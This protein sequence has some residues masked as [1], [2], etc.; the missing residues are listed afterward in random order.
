[1]IRVLT[2]PVY[3]GA[4]V[5]GELRTEDAHEPLVTREQFQRVQQMLHLNRATQTH[6]NPSGQYPFLLK[7]V[8]RCKCGHMMTSYFSTGRDGRLHF[9]Y[10]CTHRTHHGRGGC[11]APYVPA[12]AI[13]TAVVERIMA[14]TGD[15]TAQ[16]RIVRM[17]IGLA[18]EDVRRIRAET[19]RVRSRISVVQ[20][21]IGNLVR[22]LKSMGEQ[23]PVSVQEGLKECEAEKGQLTER[24]SLL[25]EEEKSLSVVTDDAERF[26]EAWRR[27]RDLFGQANPGLQRE[28]VQ[29]FIQE[30]VWMPADARGRQ[31]PTA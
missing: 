19:E 30:L 23:A 5:W 27:V 14:V 29:A 8:L 2:N 3:L 31:E 11:N 13:H 1:V 4:V 25:G 17:A 28:L 20:A 18:D 22:A 9:Y 21:E 10:A 26:L 6:R 7:G 15:Q 12:P 24:L 16:E